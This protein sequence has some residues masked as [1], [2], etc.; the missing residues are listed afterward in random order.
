MFSKTL[1]KANSLGRNVHGFTRRLCKF[2]SLCWYDAM[3]TA[4]AS[5]SLSVV[6]RSLTR[7][8][9]FDFTGIFART[10]G[11]PISMGMMAFIPYVR[12][13]GDIPV[14]FRLVIL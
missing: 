9:T 5:Q 3:R 4:A 7:A 2:A 11:I 6:S 12:A 1:L 10:V 8:S 14:G 13:N